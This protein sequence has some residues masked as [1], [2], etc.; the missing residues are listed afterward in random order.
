[1]WVACDPHW[2]PCAAAIAWAGPSHVAEPRPRQLAFDL[3]E[4]AARNIERPAS[5]GRY[6]HV[7]T[8]AELAAFERSIA[9]LDAI[10]GGLQPDERWCPGGCRKVLR[11]ERRSC[12]RRWGATRYGRLVPSGVV[13]P[14]EDFNA[15]CVTRLNSGV[16]YAKGQPGLGQRCFR[17]PKKLM[18]ASLPRTRAKPVREQPPSQLLPPSRSSQDAT[19]L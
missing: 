2:R 7:H 15:S 16:A 17:S 10:R 6:R 18:W 13:H 11:R 8:A 4:P 19:W 5:R 9:N 14:A 12:G 1:M 3:P